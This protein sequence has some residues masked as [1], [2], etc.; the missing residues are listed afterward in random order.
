MVEQDLVVAVLERVAAA[1]LAAQALT[2]QHHYRETVV[3]EQP[4]L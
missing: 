2:P 1:E 4:V 3:L